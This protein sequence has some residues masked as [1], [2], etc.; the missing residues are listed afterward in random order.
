MTLEALIELPQRTEL[1]CRE[2]APSAQPI[3]SLAAAEVVAV[4]DETAAVVV[5]ETAVVVAETDATVGS[6]VA[7]AVAV[8]ADSDAN[9]TSPLV[10]QLGGLQQ[11]T[12]TG[13][14]AYPSA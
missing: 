4:V 9:P 1:Y 5:V 8:A 6:P 10:E 14:G 11:Q 7:A 12:E 13:L 2:V 3:A